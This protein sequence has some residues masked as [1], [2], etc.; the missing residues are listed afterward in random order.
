MSAAIRCAIYTRKSSDEGLE[1]DFNSLD[2]QREACTAY[3]RSQASQGWCEMPENY[4]DGGISGGTLERPALRRLMDDVA[5]GKIDIVV[6]YKVDRLS[7]SLFDFAKLVEAFE[8]ADASFVSITQAF[9]TT[10]SMGRLTL[11]MLLSFA[12]FEREV[13]AE[14]IRDKIAA[15]KAKGMWMGGTPPLGYK[16]DGR[17]LAIVDEHAAII[18]HIFTR[19]LALG[20]VRQLEAELK[21]QK[22]MVPQRASISGKPL[23][24]V[25]FSRGTLYLIL[26]RVTYTGRIAHGEKVYPGNHPAIIDVATF[27]AVQALLASNLQGTKRTRSQSESLLAGRIVDQ[28]G[29]PLI[30][31]HATKAGAGEGCTSRYRY[32]VS[33]ALHHQET[34]SGI[35]VPA[36]EIETLVTS[37]LASMFDDP[38]ELVATAWLEVPGDRYAD[39][40]QR[41]TH[42][43]AQ[44]RLRRP[45]ALAMLKQVQVHDNRI[46]LILDTAAVA[47]ALGVTAHPSAPMIITLSDHVRL[48]RSG[49]A[50]R[51]VHGNGATASASPDC[52]LV[53][54]M[55]QARR[56][57]EELRRGEI[58]ISRLA[59]RE[60]VSAA[61]ITRVVRLA[62]L[63]PQVTA[64]I[65]AGKQRTGVNAKR[66]TLEEPI[67]ASWQQQAAS[68]L[69]IA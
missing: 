50:M 49:K 43:A 8:K 3:I 20:N 45:D 4:D 67:P 33:R 59:V 64:A 54:L 25:P 61:Y 23:G 11:N 29:A 2:A 31:T 42:I 7:R 17:S 41:C 65:L 12:Q 9:N 32:Y 13:T 36:R 19:Y 47:A 5:A 63:S 44:Q 14:R 34:T 57:W 39:V 38:V 21:A 56:W 40:Q 28:H 16:P 48:T 60:Q 18:R 66:L 46:D 35:R 1:Q 24:G 6:V 55:V 26:K 10:S 22:I 62:F 58:D 30:V 52:S 15:S 53:K 68:M 51:L 27:D 69:P 37:R